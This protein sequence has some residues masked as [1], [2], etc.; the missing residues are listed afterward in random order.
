MKVP[1]FF[2]IIKKEPLLWI[3]I[4]WFCPAQYFGYTGF[5]TENIACNSVAAARLF[6]SFGRIL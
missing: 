2:K 6:S 3:N 1:L 4:E 5:P